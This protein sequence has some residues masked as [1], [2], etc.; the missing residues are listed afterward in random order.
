MEILQKLSRIQ[1]PLIIYT[2]PTLVTITSCPDF[3]SLLPTLLCS[4]S[5]LTTAV[6]QSIL[7][8]AARKILKKT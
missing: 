8:M 5:A 6:P 2:I 1:L 7:N 3:C 4:P